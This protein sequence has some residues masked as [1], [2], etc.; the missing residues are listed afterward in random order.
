MRRIYES[1]EAHSIS[2]FNL[3]RFQKENCSEKNMQK[4]VADIKTS[5]LS[6]QDLKRKE[7]AKTYFPTRMEVIGVVSADEKAIV[8]EMRVRTKPFEV[9]Q[10]IELA[11]HLVQTNIFECQHV[12]YEYL[13]RDKHLLQELTN[14][15]ID[16]LMH[17]L[18]NWVSVDSFGVYITGVVWRLGAIDTTK[19]KSWFNS[20]DVWI[21]RLALVSTVPL[22]LKS[23]GG[24]GDSDRTLEICRL[25]V[26]DHA[27]M[28][29]KA[30][31]W[32]L[33]EL[34]KRSKTDV[35]EFIDCYET[36]LHS[37]VLREVRNKLLTG[38]KN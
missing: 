1:I 14:T 17:N 23:R 10:K 11:K 24:M 16:D 37:R 7:L 21:R 27:D 20:E 29:N 25:A 13:G 36:Q 30:L 4:I 9:V 22:N 34:S 33:R 28:I 26:N 38:K 31:S 5:L 15:D 18:D 19:I 32:A 12:A 35:E 8:K 2:S 6:F 3:H